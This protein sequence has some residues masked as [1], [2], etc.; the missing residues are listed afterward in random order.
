VGLSLPHLKPYV[1]GELREFMGYSFRFEPAQLPTLRTLSKGDAIAL[2]GKVEVTSLM[3]VVEKCELVD[4]NSDELSVLE[5]VKIN[6][7]REGG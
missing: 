7:R 1:D 4:L 5:A 2:V 3:I 6:N